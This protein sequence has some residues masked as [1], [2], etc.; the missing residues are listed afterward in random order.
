MKRASGSERV[1]GAERGSWGP[2]SDAVGG[3][4]GAKPPGLFLKRRS[5]QPW[6]V[7]TRHFFRGLFDF[8]VL[9][10]TGAEAFKRLMLGGAAVALAL[11]LLLARIFRTKYRILAGLQSQDA[12]D[13]AIVSDHAFLI[14]VPMWIV[15]MAVTLVGHALFPDETDYRI[16]LAQPVSRAVVFGSKLLALL[17]F[18]GLIV[19]ATHTALT[20]L[21]VLTA[22]SRLADVGFVQHLIVFET[23]NLAASAFA[24]L[25]VV[26]LH[27][28]LILLVP[29][30]HL[31]AW[32]AAVRSLLIC[33]LV[34]S[35]PLVGRLPAVGTAVANDAP[36]LLAVPP[37]WFT[38]LEHWLLDATAYLGA[39]FARTAVLA[40]TIAGLVAIGCYL[41]L[42]LRFD[43]VLMRPQ[44]SRPLWRERRRRS[45]G[46]RQPIRAAVAAFVGATLRRSVL[47]QGVIVAFAAVAAGLVLNGVIGELPQWRRSPA[48]ARPA[49]TIFVIWAPFVFMYIMSRSVRLA[50]SVPIEP[51]ANWIFRMTEDARTRAGA[52]AA[53]VSAIVRLGVAVPLALLLPLQWLLL[54]PQALIVAGVAAAIGWLHAEFLLHDW[55]RVPFTCSYIP[56]KGFVP[57]LFL[58]TLLTF[59]GFTI[60]GV[61]LIRIALAIP[62]AAAVAGGIA[63]AAAL[64][65]RARRRR[66]ADMPLTFEDELPTDLNV[67][68]LSSD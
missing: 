47:H 16:L 25:A 18:A 3:S 59:L 49:M 12:Y 32:S 8:G 43:R 11:G 57:Q 33:A 38:G 24:V 7:L 13:L 61:V 14:A 28:L 10:D 2:A 40:A 52:I 55:R 23:V 63:S 34:L 53:S 67:L 5:E 9:S 44:S 66:D 39:P 1:G 4:A 20:P 35:L 36:W 30:T 19:V 62:A 68:R 50:L 58:R 51:R 48:S 22:V 21:F 60:G 45:P 64:A 46:S 15:A 27:G 56:G 17:L 37:L 29:R 65:L 54:G 31:A 26:S 6:Y 42:Y 41:H